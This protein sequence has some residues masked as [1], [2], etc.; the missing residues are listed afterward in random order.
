MASSGGPLPTLAEGGHFR[1]HDGC[2]GAGCDECRGTG[3]AT[4]GRA[5]LEALEA[6]AAASGRSPS[7]QPARVAGDQLAFD[8]GSEER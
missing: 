8:F 1:I 3:Y 7:P 2:G 4:Y 5:A 6:R